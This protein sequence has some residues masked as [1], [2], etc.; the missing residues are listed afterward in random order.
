[1]IKSG[2]LADAGYSPNYILSENDR[3]HI[4]QTLADYGY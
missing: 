3:Y 1:M 4:K 2:D